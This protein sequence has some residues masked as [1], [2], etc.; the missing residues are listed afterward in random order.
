M[1]DNIDACLARLQ[2]L[3][4][5]IGVGLV[6]EETGFLMGQIEAERN[7]L[8]LQLAAAANTEVVRSKRKAINTLQLDDTIEDILITL[9][10]HYHLIRPSRVRPNLF[11]YLALDKTRANL[12]LARMMLNEAEQE[13]SIP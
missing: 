7:T 10:K 5:F 8:N 9:G 1:S 3:A 12:A 4:G 2:N 11:F 6:D 13:L